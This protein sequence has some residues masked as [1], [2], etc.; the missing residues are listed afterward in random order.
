MA[1]TIYDCEGKRERGWKGDEEGGGAHTVEDDDEMVVKIV[2]NAP[3]SP[4]QYFS[5]IFH[6]FTRLSLV[7]P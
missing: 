4:L 7:P 3:D 2:F 6:A 1:T 5:V